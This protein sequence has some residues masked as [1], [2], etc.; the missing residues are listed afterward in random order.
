[1]SRGHK[2]EIYRKRNT[3]GLQ[4]HSVKEITTKHHFA[5]LLAECPP[6][7]VALIR[8]CIHIVKYSGAHKKE[9]SSICTNMEQSPRSEQWMWYVSVCIS[10]THTHTCK[11]TGYQ[12]THKK[13]AMVVTSRE[14]G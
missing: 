1:M 11:G 6:L 13:L 7:G 14:G 5:T 10:C 3:N 9:D 4:P 12:I 8:W 2:Q